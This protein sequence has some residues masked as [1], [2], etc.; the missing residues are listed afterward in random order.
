MFLSFPFYFSVFSLLL[1]S[2]A[3]RLILNKMVMMSKQY[4]LYPALIWNGENRS[5]YTVFFKKRVINVFPPLQEL[6][7]GGEKKVILVC[8]LVVWFILKD[9]DLKTHLLFNKVAN[10]PSVDPSASQ[11]LRQGLVSSPRQSHSR[12]RSLPHVTEETPAWC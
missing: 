8:S 3:G 4:K 9:F 1:S 7:S 11:P 10:T 5:L 2:L 12:S 6:Y